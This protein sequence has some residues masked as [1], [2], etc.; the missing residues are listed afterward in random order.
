[1]KIRN[2]LPARHPLPGGFPL[3]AA[4]ASIPCGTLTCAS[5]VAGGVRAWQG[6]HTRRMPPKYLCRLRESAMC[7]DEDKSLFEDI[8]L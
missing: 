2:A 3:P 8:T 7:P 6:P 4:A 1:M 5:T